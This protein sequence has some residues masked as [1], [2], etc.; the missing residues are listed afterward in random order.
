MSKPL[1]LG[2]LYAPQSGHQTHDESFDP[3]NPADLT[4]LAQNLEAA[5]FAFLL[6]DDSV[7]Q[8]V[9]A[10]SEAFTTASFLATRT[11]HIGLIASANTSYVEPYNAARLAASL[12][13]VTHGRAG[14]DVSTGALHPA[15]ANYGQADETPDAH[16]DRADE[17]VGIARRLWDSW[18]D[19][20]FVRDKQSGVFVDGARIHAIDHQGPRFNVKGPLNV[21]RPPQ[22]HVIVVHR[23]ADSRSAA[24][25]GRHADIAILAA[26]RAENLATLRDIVLG[27]ASAAHRDRQHVRL[28]AE[29]V[30]VVGPDDA[31]AAPESLA[32]HRLTGSP[33]DIADA[34]ETLADAAELDG[35]LVTLPVLRGGADAFS[36]HVIPELARRQRLRSRAGA[37][38][39]RERLGLQRPRNIFETAATLPADTAA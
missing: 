30:A 3:F 16:Y 20:A 26:G 31:A 11:R 36:L 25:A 34:I 24:F 33:S 14:W 13:H 12:D 9:P 28:F 22:G 4:T 38:T 39:L 32:G 21:A 29:I 27:S 10:R 18:E 7:G 6:I 17:I 23:V 1:H 37:I 2:F 8:A 19:D 15:G 35:L 5:D